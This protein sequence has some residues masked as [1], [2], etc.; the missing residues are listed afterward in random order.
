VEYP[1][2]LDAASDRQGL[3]PPADDLDLGKLRHVG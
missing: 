2:P 3:E 1:D